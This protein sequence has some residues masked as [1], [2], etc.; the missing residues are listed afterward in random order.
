VAVD[1]VAPILE[2]T[3]EST[4]RDPDLETVR[5]AVPANLL[6]LRGMA[7]EYPQREDLRELVALA[8]FSFAMAFVE[9]TEPDRAS[10]L[11]KEG[12][13]LGRESLARSDWFRKAEAEKPIPTGETLSEIED[14]DVPVLFWTLANWMRWVSLNLD[15]PAAVAMIPRI[16]LYLHRVI[17]L[18][19]D[20]YEGLP[21]AMLASIQGFRPQLLGGKPEESKR[22][23]QEAFRISGNRML[24]FHVLYA[25]FYCRQVLD[26]DCFDA[27]LNE[28]LAAP[29]GL[30]PDF[31]LWNEVAKDKARYLLEIRDE[32]F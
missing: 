14:G 10:L 24:L 27:T 28:V 16:E 5:E 31:R 12:W 19:S 4:F 8:Y 13:R 20:Y 7:E 18:R 25:Q 22:N 32:L 1:S 26:E 3:L 9:D 6:L 21:Y 23:F 11:Y 15:D 17:E 29:E 30:F 2:S